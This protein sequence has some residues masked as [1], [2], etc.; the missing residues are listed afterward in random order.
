[1]KKNIFLL[2]ICFCFSSAIAQPADEEKLNV[3]DAFLWLNQNTFDFNKKDSTRWFL[4]INESDD[5]MRLHNDAVTIEVRLWYNHLGGTLVAATV[6]ESDMVMSHQ[7][8][9]YYH[10]K[11]GKYVPF[12]RTTEFNLSR[13]F[14]PAYLIKNNISPDEEMPDYLLRLPEKGDTVI[15]SLQTEIFDAQYMGDD[16]LTRLDPN[17]LRIEELGI[18]F[19]GSEFNIVSKKYRIDSTFCLVIENGWDDWCTNENYFKK[20]AADQWAFSDK[21]SL[22]GDQCFQVEANLPHDSITVSERFITA[23]GKM[24]SETE[25]IIFYD[26][27]FEKRN[28]KI[29]LLYG[30]G[31][32]SPCK[33]TGRNIFCLGKHSA[34]ENKTLPKISAKQADAI[35]IQNKPDLFNE[36]NEAEYGNDFIQMRKIKAYD[37]MIELE[38]KI[39]YEGKFRQKYISIH[40][41]HGEC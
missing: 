34:P 11:N 21:V 23:W 16:P 25:G 35:L 39:Y 7:N 24:V 10:Y 20:T 41:R 37:Y 15:L 14:E 3:G 8:F 5:F 36:K 30:T 22:T 27:V 2:L 13:F 28:E 19:N 31:K 6:T 26:T 17:E 33:K 40:I 4:N 18:V 29:K 38:I 9:Y 12:T 1:M 32:F